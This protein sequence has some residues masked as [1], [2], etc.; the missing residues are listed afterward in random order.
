[1]G[2]AMFK[3]FFIA[4]LITIP[5]GT[6]IEYLFHRFVMHSHRFAIITRR[7]RLHHKANTAD[8]LWSDFRDFMMGAFPF[9]WCGFFYSIPAGIGFLF[10]SVLYTFCLALVHKLSHDQPRLIFWMDPN[11]HELHHGITPQKNF[12]VITRFWDRVFGTYASGRF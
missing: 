7:H 11:S 6:L 8:T 2:L 4:F 5:Y 10:G 12:G 1:M 9:C 3:E